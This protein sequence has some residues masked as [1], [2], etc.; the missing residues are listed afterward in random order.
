[1]GVEVNKTVC[2]SAPYLRSDSLRLQG[3]AAELSQNCFYI[4]PV[5]GGNK[6]FPRHV[7]TRCQGATLAGIPGSWIHLF[8]FACVLTFR[9]CLCL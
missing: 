5:Q 3:W 9:S 4:P 1:M 8:V 7:S 2:D 6:S